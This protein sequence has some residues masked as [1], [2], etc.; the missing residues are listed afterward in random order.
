[1]FIILVGIEFGNLLMQR[2]KKLNYKDNFFL[3]ETYKVNPN[4]TVA[5]LGHCVDYVYIVHLPSYSVVV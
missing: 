4:G 3:K 5:T 1:M 2:T